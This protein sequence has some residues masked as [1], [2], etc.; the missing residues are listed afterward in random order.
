M[1][2]AGGEPGDGGEH[3]EVAEGAHGGADFLVLGEEAPLGEENFP[4]G[5]AG[6]DQGQG[7]GAG[8]GHVG[9]DVGKIFEEPEAAKSEASDFALPE[10]IEGAQKR[11]EQF[12]EGSAK[13][14]NGVAK[15][16][17]EEMAA[18][19]DDQIDEIQE[20]KSGAVGEGV[21]KEQ[22]VEAEPG[23]SREAGDG[24]PGAEFFFE[25]GHLLQRSKAR[26]GK[27]TVVSYQ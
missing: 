6:A 21:E 24:F 2:N 3:A 22:G 23:D 15:P 27:A 8:V 25:E 13:N 20:E 26:R 7:C 14:H 1:A 12:A 10:E 9:A 11:H 18:F 5:V 19:V 17:E 4:V 16:T